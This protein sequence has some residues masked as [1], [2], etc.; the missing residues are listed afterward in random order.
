M[1]NRKNLRVFLLAVAGVLAASAGVANAA[2]IKSYDF[3]GDLTDTL[4]NGV[5]IYSMLMRD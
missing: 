2:L 5:S 1:L 4:G 3:D